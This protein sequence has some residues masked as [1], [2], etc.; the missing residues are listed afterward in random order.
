MDMY[1]KTTHIFLK[2]IKYKFNTLHVYAFPVLH[3]RE[4]YMFPFK[5]ISF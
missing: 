5:K 4:L 1:N 3:G 2:K